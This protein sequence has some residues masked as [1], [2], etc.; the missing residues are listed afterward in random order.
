LANF[1]P[2]DKIEEIKNAA[3]IV[4]VVSEY[5]LLK[6][7]RAQLQRSVPLSLREDPFLYRQP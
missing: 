2:E 6:K 7:N 3:D 4:E 5:V 1:I